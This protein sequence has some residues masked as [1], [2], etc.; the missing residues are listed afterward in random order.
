LSRLQVPAAPDPLDPIILQDQ[1]LDDWGSVVPLTERV[2]GAV[3]GDAR[4]TLA[5]TLVA[6][7]YAHVGRLAE[8][9]AVAAQ[10]STD[11]IP[12]LIARG[13]VAARKH[14]WA[15]ADAWYAEAVRQS[16]SV[17]DAPLAWGQALLDRGDI[18]GAIAKLE[19]AHRRGPHYADPLEAWGEALLRKGDYAGAIAK[20]A[21][22]DKDA[23]RWGRNHMRWGDALM[24]SSRYR[25]ARA[26]YEAANGMDLSKPDRAA[27]DVLLAR[28][29]SGPL[30]G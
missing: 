27:L 6:Q 20:F 30:H 29:A 28:T 12:C 7:A 1:V 15:Q 26:Q 13:F 21:E 9:Q 23:P 5:P 4:T 17:P 18:D 16:P 14:D 22:A 11:C 10:T 19:E 3:K 8:A 24:L 25:E 2:L